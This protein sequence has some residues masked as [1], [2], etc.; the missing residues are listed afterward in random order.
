MSAKLKPRLVTGFGVFVVSLLL[1]VRHFSSLG[2]TQFDEGVYAISG[3]WS[4]VSPHSHPLYPWQRYFAPP[5][6]FGLIGI[7]YWL[8]GGASDLAAIAPNLLLGAA[9]PVLVWWIGERWFGRSCGLFAALLA[10]TSEFNIVFSRTA[11]ADTAFTFFFLL[12][13]AL[14]AFYFESGNV[15]IGIA[16]GLSVGATWNFKYHGWMP[17]AIAALALF[18]DSIRHRSVSRIRTLVLPWA[19]VSIVAV[20]CFLPWLIYVNSL[21]G[22]YLAVERFHSQFVDFHWKADFVRQAQMVLWF[23][24]WLSRLSPAACFLIAIVLSKERNAIRSPSVLWGFLALLVSGISIGGGGTAALLAIPG[25]VIAWR[26]RTLLGMMVVLTFAVLTLVTPFYTPYAR[27]LLPWI[28]SSQ[29]LAG[30]SIGTY[31]RSESSGREYP[32]RWIGIPFPVEAGGFIALSVVL[33]AV[34]GASIPAE[35]RAWRSSSMTR[36]AAQEIMHHLPSNAFLAVDQEPALAFYFRRA[37]L[38]TVCVNQLAQIQAPAGAPIV[39]IAGQYARQTPDWNPVVRAEGYELQR[40][41]GI[42]VL[43]SEVQLLDDLAPREAREFLTHPDGRYIVEAYR[44]IPS[45]HRDRTGQR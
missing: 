34:C 28:A 29:F 25:S 41:G 22:G 9:T 10:A 27:L 30:I 21:P 1:R 17:L 20:V 7:A 31:V 43:P 42:A 4:Q 23:D 3:F 8:A 40:A 14:I 6:Y 5:G 16:A 45:A 38:A 33:M 24:G 12:S 15:G 26:S 2:L 11:L 32:Q 39:L 36:I 44:M 18:F 19:L 35:T 37:G 13:L